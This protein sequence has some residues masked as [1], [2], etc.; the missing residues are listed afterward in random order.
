MVQR[1]RATANLVMQA[2][3]HFFQSNQSPVF[4]LQDSHTH[5]CS[6][7]VSRHGEAGDLRVC[8]EWHLQFLQYRPCA[9][10]HTHIQNKGTTERLS[11][12]DTTERFASADRSTQT[13][14]QQE[15]QLRQQQSLLLLLALCVALLL[16][17]AHTPGVCP[18]DAENGKLNKT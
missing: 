15:Q 5:S 3:P 8:A 13:E 11:S 9:H 1:C 7:E 2:R 4:V 16:M 14:K 18:T 12:E 17:H 6:N 10:T